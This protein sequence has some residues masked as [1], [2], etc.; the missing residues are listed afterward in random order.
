[1]D[2]D[3][4]FYKVSSPRIDMTFHP[5]KF[6]HTE[7]WESSSSRPREGYIE[8]TVLFAGDFDEVSIHL[9][10]RVR[11]VRVRAVDA[12]ATHLRALGMTCCSGMTA[13]IFVPRSRKRE[14]ESF[15]PT[16]F[17]FQPHGFTR[18]RRG[19]YVSWQ[20]QTA[21]SSETISMREALATWNTEAC[22]VDDLDVVV[23][24][25]STARIYFDE[26]T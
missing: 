22:Y 9:F 14:V 18:V 15:H 2:M 10:P 5:S 26:Q 6:W 8:D 12:E 13:H 1:M 11:T 16:V 20:P 23:R 19:E 3:L 7:D 4:H 17:K 24:T 25:L 21:T